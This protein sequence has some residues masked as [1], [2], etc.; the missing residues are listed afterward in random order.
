MVAMAAFAQTFE[1]AGELISERP[2]VPMVDMQR[3][4]TAAVGTAKV[5]QLENLHLALPPLRCTPIHLITG[6]PVVSDASAIECSVRPEAQLSKMDRR[7]DCPHIHI[8]NCSPV[9]PCDAEYRSESHS[10]RMQAHANLSVLGSL[11]DAGRTRHQ[12]RGVTGI[13]SQLARAS[14]IAAHQSLRSQTAKSPAIICTAGSLV[15]SDGSFR[16]PAFFRL[17][18]ASR[19]QVLLRNGKALLFSKSSE[20]L[21]A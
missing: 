11:S 5:L 3:L 10:S 13:V 6:A 18:D 9:N 7:Q 20:A 1:I 12:T 8:A 19:D 17:I 4:L 21:D 2:V 15:R 16:I 14:A